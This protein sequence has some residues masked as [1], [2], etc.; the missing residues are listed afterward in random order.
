MK[1]SYRGRVRKV[2][3]IPQTMEEFQRVIRQ[4]FL[5]CH[6]PVPDEE[7]SKMMSRIMD[8]SDATGDTSELSKMI[9]AQQLRDSA[10]S[11]LEESAVGGKRRKRDK[12]VVDFADN[13]CFYEDSE[14]DL[15]VLSEDEDLSDATKYCVQHNDKTLKCSIVPRPFYEELR[16]EQM[17]SDLNQSQTWEQSELNQFRPQAKKE[18]KARKQATKEQDRIPVGMMSKF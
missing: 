10:G 4:K 11:P 7:E 8:E 17:L 16:R 18:K 2:N 5:N 15:N 9:R 6:F 12:T 1:V 14:G 13:V 3:V